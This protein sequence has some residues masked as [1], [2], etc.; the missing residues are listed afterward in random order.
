MNQTLQ[1]K[2]SR[3][4]EIALSRLILELDAS[5]RELGASS[6]TVR[7]LAR[8]LRERLKADPVKEA[9]EVSNAR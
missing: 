3:L 9:A 6:A 5:E 2:P 8:E 7:V 1:P 4:S